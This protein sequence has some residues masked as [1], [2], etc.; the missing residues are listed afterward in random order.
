[1]SVYAKQFCD[2]KMIKVISLQKL[3]NLPL[4]SDVS[5]APLTLICVPTLTLSSVYTVSRFLF[6]LLTSYAIS[7]FACTLSHPLYLR[8]L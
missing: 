4:L 7:S 8:Y 1:M 5:L 2:N 3:Q 6:T